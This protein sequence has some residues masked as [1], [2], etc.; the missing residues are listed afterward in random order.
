MAYSE[1]T[2]SINGILGTDKTVLQNMETLAGA[3]ASWVTYDSHDGLWSVVINE[4]GT[5]VASF[6]DSNIIGAIAIAGTGL[7]G[8]YNSV[9]V[10]FPHIDLND[11][12]D[13]IHDSM[14]A[15]DLF[16]NEI[17]NVLNIQYDIINDP[18]QAEYL[19]L[20]E[21]KQNRLDLV[22][23]FKT[24]FSQI[25]L[26]AGDLIDITSTT[27]GFVNRMFRIEKLVESDTDDGNI[28]IAITAREYSESVYSTDDLYR[29]IRT[30]STGIQTIGNIGIPGTPSVSKIEQDARPRVT[31]SS[32]TPTGTVDALEFWYTPDTY[33][34]DENRVYQLLDRVKPSFG[35][36]FPFGN[37]VTITTDSL[38]SGNFY[39]KTRGVNGQTLGPFSEPSGFV[40]TPVQTTNN[41]DENTTASSSTGALVT[42]LG[43][44]TLLN[45]LDQLFLGNTATGSMFK[46]VFDL[47]S[48]NTGYDLVSQAGNLNTITSN[49]NNVMISAASG[50]FTVSGLGQSSSNSSFSQMGSTIT[51]T[52]KISGSYKVDV[53]IDQNTSGA[54]GGRG[55]KYAIV[56]GDNT[57]S[58]YGITVAG[59]TAGTSFDPSQTAQVAQLYL[60]EP[61]DNIQA[62]FG[63]YSS[64]G[65]YLAGSAS[66]GS[67]AQYWNDFALTDRLDL[68]AGDTYSIKFFYVNWTESA[69][70]SD[71]SFDVG[72]NIYCTS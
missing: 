49:T 44:L 45:N 24:D 12:K 25:G 66:G 70:T 41:I 58:P 9:R 42:A 13:F 59:V 4:A 18:L 8:L 3:A 19:G 61:E 71:I 34:L 67:G 40:Y 6:D 16:P 33:T 17:D 32:T 57:Q 11:E 68:V 37:T 5:S 64:I 43:A 60:Q 38:N 65:G 15:G 51:F 2:Y 46:K 20:V 53:I 69:P 63:I 56:N 27:Y 28:E 30:N 48:S 36:T 7:D 14:P 26:K 22:V 50:K 23:Q 21:L 39:V 35:N 10:E 1:Y 47:F 54:N 55:C 72:Y 31:I 29:Y 52:P 62:S